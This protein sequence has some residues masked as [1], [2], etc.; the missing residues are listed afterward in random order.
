MW[1]GSRLRHLRKKLGLTQ[2][3]VAKRV[4]KAVST[5][6]GYETNY[7]EPDS[8]TLVEL[9]MIL[10]T[11]TDFLLGLSDDDTQ[12]TYRHNKLPKFITDAG[13]D[14][15]PFLKNCDLQDLTLEEMEA[16]IQIVKRIKERQDEEKDHP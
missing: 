6:S 3:Y 5:L 10:N 16:L 4:N 8:A 1:D 15:L 14:T 11:T 7:S 12:K 9:A 13:I 2:D